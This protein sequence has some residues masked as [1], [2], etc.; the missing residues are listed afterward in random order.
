MSSPR[1]ARSPD[2]ARLQSEGYEVDVRGGHLV[3]TNIPYVNAD[4]DVQRGSM[5]AALTESGDRAGKPCD[6]TVWWAGS[7]PCHHTGEP[8]TAIHNGA[9]DQDVAPG[10]HVDHRF[11]SK[12]PSGAYDNYHH[13]FTSYI[14]LI[15]N[16]AV[17]LDATVTPRTFD[18][19][20]TDP[21]ESVHRYWDTATTRAGIAMANAKLEMDKLAVVGLGGSGAYVLDF[22]VKSPPGEIHLFDGDDLLNHN[23]F[24]APG[25]VPLETLRN[26][27]KK[28]DYYAELYG[29]LHRGLV[30]HPYFLDAGNAVELADMRFVFLCMDSGPAK[31]ELIE[32]M[33]STGIPFVDVGMGL[34]ER[35]ASVGGILRV[36]LST[37][38]YRE[39]QEK[40]DF[41]D[42]DDEANEYGRNIQVIDLNALCA[43]LAVMR[44]KRFCGFYRDYSG[45]HTM[46][47]TTDTNTL[48]N[49][50]TI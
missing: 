39:A 36:T 16:E 40:I 34:G 32:F 11:S 8:M 25:A 13:Q 17:A 33:D 37:P 30:A 10:L 12:P 1:I 35:D 49:E 14:A 5:L 27:P 4:G 44:W 21:E 18:P 42:P 22:V 7:Q 48:L 2:L 46:L 23:A 38:E 20:E 29:H 41:A 26:R 47:F 45:E 28:V 31:R 19:V 43:C 15:S 9:V 50:D 3:V 24:R 6:H